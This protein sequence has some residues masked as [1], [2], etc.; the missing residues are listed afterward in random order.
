MAGGDRC[1]NM[2]LAHAGAGG[3]ATEQG[4]SFRDEPGVPG[5]SVLVLKCLQHPEGIDPPRESGSIQA[6]ER[7]QG[8]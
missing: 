5:R 3:G 1:F 8:I 6:H 4:Q 2:V 7:R